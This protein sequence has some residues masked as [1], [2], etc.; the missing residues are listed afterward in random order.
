MSAKTIRL[1]AMMIL[2]VMLMLMMNIFSYRIGKD[3]GFQFGS[4]HGYARGQVDLA[5]DIQSA[6]GE[7][8]DRET[9]PHVYHP[10]KNIKDI[11]LYI[12]D[13][14]GVKTLAIWKSQ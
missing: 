3:K 8:V 13:R 4:V 5:W 12:V 14:N 9:D 11:T 7:T 2:V 6:I 1:N 10:F